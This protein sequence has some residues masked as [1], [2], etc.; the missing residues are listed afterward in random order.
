MKSWTESGNPIYKALPERKFVGLRSEMDA[1]ITKY[2]N[3]RNDWKILRDELNL[4]ATTDLTHDEIYYIKIDP[5]DSRFNYDIPNGN[6]GGAI[7]GEWVPGGTTKNGTLEAA[8]VG[9]ETCVH[10]NKMDTL[11]EFFGKGKWEKIK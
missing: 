1:V 3:A 4:G 6:E 5:S 2:K 9:C 8:L 7:P 11:L 10:D